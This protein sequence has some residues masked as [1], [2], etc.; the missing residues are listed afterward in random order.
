MYY[1]ST[2]NRGLFKSY[3][4]YFCYL[5]IPSNII[6]MFLIPSLDIL[7]KKSSCQQI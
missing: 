4:S 1:L 7:D 3:Y 2:C 6:K 5:K